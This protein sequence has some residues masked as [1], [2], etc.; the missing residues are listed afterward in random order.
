MPPPPP[1][2]P[3]QPT[4]AIETNRA[5]SATMASQLRRLGTQTRKTSARAVPPAEGQNSLLVRLRAL[6]AAVVPMVKVDVTAD[7]PV[8]LA[9]VGDRLHVAGS[10]EAVGLMEQVKAT[11][12]VNPPD[13]VTLIVDVLPDVAPGFTVM[14]P[15]LDSANEPVDVVEFTVRVTGVVSVVEPF[16]PVTVTV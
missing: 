7:V 13:G 10:L 11:V 12:P 4:A 6:V 8:M 1:P 16:V 9:E 3:P 5:S 14:L 2:P 15:P